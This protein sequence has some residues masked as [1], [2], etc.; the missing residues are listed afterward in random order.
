VI[1]ISVTKPR[2]ETLLQNY[3]I[4]IQMFK[5]LIFIFATICALKGSEASSSSIMPKLHFRNMKNVGWRL[6]LSLIS[7]GKVSTECRMLTWIQKSQE[8]KL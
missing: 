2:G 4:E 6:P 1:V 7:T 3:P 5:V 8:T